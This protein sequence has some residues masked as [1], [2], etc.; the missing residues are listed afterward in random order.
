V[1]PSHSHGGQCGDLRGGEAEFERDCD[2]RVS[3]VVQAD[4]LKLA[5][6]LLPAPLGPM[7]A[8][9]SPSSKSSETP[10]TATAGPYWTTRL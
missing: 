2:E 6:E 1:S 9:R 5:S 8:T 4:R 7:S 10:S 3:E